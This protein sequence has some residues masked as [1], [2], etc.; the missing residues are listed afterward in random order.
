[1]CSPHLSAITGVFVYRHYADSVTYG[2]VEE[3]AQHLPALAG[4]C[5]VAKG[6]KYKRQWEVW[7]KHEAQ[8]QNGEDCLT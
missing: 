8:L 4:P 3:L 2:V 6:L 1:M 5:M 7:G